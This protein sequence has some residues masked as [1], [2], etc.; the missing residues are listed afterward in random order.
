ME[1]EK[2]S[3]QLCSSTPRMNFAGPRRIRN[4]SLTSLP[5]IFLA[6]RVAREALCGWYERA[7]GRAKTRLLNIQRA[8]NIEHLE[9]LGFSLEYRSERLN[10]M[11]FVMVRNAVSGCSECVLVHRRNYGAVTGID[12]HFFIN[13]HLKT[14][15]QWEHDMRLWIS[16]DA[17]WHAYL[18]EQLPPEDPPCDSTNCHHLLGSSLVF[19]IISFG[20]AQNTDAAVGQQVQQA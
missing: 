2:R 13:S 4:R 18:R 12:I 17:P 20:E 7:F 11:D 15:H 8:Q 9:R 14:K 10:S 16:R 19:N 3:H 1:T 6:R 5:P